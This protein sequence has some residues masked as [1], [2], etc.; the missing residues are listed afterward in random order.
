MLSRRAEDNKVSSRKSKKVAKLPPAR[1]GNKDQLPPRQLIMSKAGSAS[2]LLTAAETPHGGPNLAANTKMINKAP[3]VALIN[4]SSDGHRLVGPL[5]LKKVEQDLIKRRYNQHQYPDTQIRGNYQ[6]GANH[7]SDQ[8]LAIGRGGHLHPQQ[9]PDTRNS[10]NPYIK[11]AKDNGTT[12]PSSLPKPGYAGS[13]S[14]SGA[15]MQTRLP[16]IS[17]N[18]S[19]ASSISTGVTP[20]SSLAKYLPQINTSHSVANLGVVG[21]N[22]S[23]Q[24]RSLNLR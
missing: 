14:H 20:Q 23:S 16:R 22:N 1:L 11:Y 12:T 5:G 7:R 8:V 4:I 10:Q 6:S 9:Y 19:A 17:S 24:F 3:S 18:H 2:T 15:Q 13:N 21:R